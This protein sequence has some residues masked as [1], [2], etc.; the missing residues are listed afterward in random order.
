MDKKAIWSKIS[1]DI[2]WSP[3]NLTSTSSLNRS[4][5]HLYVGAATHGSFYAGSIHFEVFGQLRFASLCWTSF[6]TNCAAR[7]SFFRRGVLQVAS[8][9]AFRPHQNDAITTFFLPQGR[10]RPA[11]WRRDLAEKF[12]QSRRWCKIVV[13][14]PWYIRTGH[15]VVRPHVPRQ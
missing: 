11:D 6:L 4:W 8:L 15:A 13:T 12:F 9:K 2:T 14:S 10:I 1:R 7:R 5:R 3:N